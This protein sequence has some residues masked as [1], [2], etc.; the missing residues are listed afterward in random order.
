MPEKFNETIAYKPSMEGFEN[1][2]AEILEVDSVLLEDKL[3]SFDAWDS[4][5]ILSIMAYSDTE[6]NVALAAEEIISS[7][8]VGGLKKLIRSKM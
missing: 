2:I 4:L 6:F 3:C 1:S 5:T 7:G 8:T